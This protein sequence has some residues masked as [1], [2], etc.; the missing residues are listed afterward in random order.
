M[1]EY[2]RIFQDHLTKLRRLALQQL[3]T[4]NE[5]EKVIHMLSATYSM[6]SE[7]DQKAVSDA[8]KTVVRLTEGQERGLTEAIKS[9]LQSNPKGWFNA[10]EVRDQLQESGFDFSGYTSNPLSS[11]HSVLKRFKQTEVKTRIGIDASKEYQWIMRF[12]RLSKRRPMYSIPRN[13]AV[14]PPGYESPDLLN[15]LPKGEKEK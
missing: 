3:E 11:V 4:R 10:I 8:F 9:V 13:I 7:N 2:L 6:L 14:P 5:I 15:L 12:P 1:D